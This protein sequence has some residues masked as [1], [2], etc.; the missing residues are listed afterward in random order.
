MISECGKLLAE[1]DA[2]EYDQLDDARQKRAPEMHDAARRQQPKKKARSDAGP[3]EATAAAAQ[4]GDA[5]ASSSTVLE[6]PPNANAETPDAAPVGD[7]S[8]AAYKHFTSLLADRFLNSGEGL[9]EAD[10][11]LR[12]AKARLTRARSVFSTLGHPP[13]VGLGVPPNARSYVLM[14]FSALEADDV[15]YAKQIYSMLCQSKPAGAVVA[16]EGNPVS[17]PA[18]APASLVPVERMYEIMQPSFI[19][20]L[21]SAG[22]IPQ[23]E[24]DELLS[25]SANTSKWFFLKSVYE[26]MKGDQFGS[27]HGAVLT[28]ASSAP[29]AASA[30][31]SSSAPA[32]AVNPSPAAQP[33]STTYLSHGR[34]HRFA[35]QGDKHV[36]VM[37]SE[38]HALVR[39]LEREGKAR[40]GTAASSSSAITWTKGSNSS[41]SSAGASS[42]A[43]GGGVGG[44]AAGCECWIVE[45]DGQ[46]V[47]YEEA[48]PCPMCNKGLHMLGVS[49]VHYSSHCGVKSEVLRYKPE[50]NCESYEMALKRHY[51]EGT[52]DPDVGDEPEF[53]FQKLLD[54]GRGKNALKGS[55]ALA[56]GAAPS[57]STEITRANVSVSNAAP[58]SS[59]PAA[60]SS[61]SAP[62]HGKAECCNSGCEHCVLNEE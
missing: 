41:S 60:T 4:G 19:Q 13:P 38:V 7:A 1:W 56:D 11:H 50:L 53:D 35:V 16:A 49:K 51:P 9:S 12:Y 5:D 31:S 17:S 21:A 42:A 52:A 15:E 22:V 18:A 34:N 40:I 45:L 6:S 8:S 14:L 58:H 10:L 2:G 3:G 54:P 20:R 24:A 62:G 26:G 25:A 36:R 48:V 57:A 23:R 27:K 28:S 44:P 46:G 32:A 55:T 47:G 29:D 30:S 43:A 61:A 37:H 33:S 59:A 39:Y